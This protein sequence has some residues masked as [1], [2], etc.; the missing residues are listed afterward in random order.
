MQDPE[1]EHSRC[2]LEFL[3]LVADAGAHRTEH[4][5]PLDVHALG[6]VVTQA[7]NDL[8]AAGDPR[9]VSC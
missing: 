4:P 7:G 5:L 6:H 3:Y 1:G 9:Q 2:L 8:K